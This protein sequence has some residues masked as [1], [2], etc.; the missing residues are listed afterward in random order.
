MALCVVSSY[1]HYTED[2]YHRWNSFSFIKESREREEESMLLC[3]NKQSNTYTRG[4]CMRSVHF[5]LNMIKGEEKYHFSVAHS[6]F[7]IC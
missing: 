3:T 7:I 5:E 6:I 2:N 4:R 1:S